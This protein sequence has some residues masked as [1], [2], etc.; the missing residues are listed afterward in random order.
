MSEQRKSHPLVDATEPNL[1]ERTFDYSLPPLL[2]F[3]GPVIEVMDGRQVEF[4]PQ[5]LLTRDIFVTDTTFRDGQQA[6]PP[7]TVEQMVHIYDL[8]A[9]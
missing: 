3:D 4:D 1:L 5:L 2:R 6:Q 9:K 7:Y 8:L